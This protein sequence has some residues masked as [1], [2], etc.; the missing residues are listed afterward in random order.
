[1]G[2]LGDIYR[3]VSSVGPGR[4]AL[5]LTVEKAVSLVVGF[6]VSILIARHLGPE[7]FGVFSYV[8]AWIAVVAPLATLG[9]AGP[10]V[11]S[12][13]QD[14]LNTERVITT[15]MTLRLVAAV[16]V[17]LVVVGLIGS[18]LLVAGNG[19]GIGN[20]KDV[21]IVLSLQYLAQSLDVFEY[22]NQANGRIIQTVRAR[23]AAFMVVSALRVAAVYLGA[24]VVTFAWLVVLQLLLGFALIYFGTKPLMLRGSW[25]FDSALARKLLGMGSFIVLAGLLNMAQAR[26]EMIILEHFV[27]MKAV[28]IYAAALRF[29]ELFD[30][31][32]MIAVTIYL[33]HLLASANND[34]L[35]DGKLVR[36]YRMAILLYLVCI[37]L[38]VAMAGIAWWTMGDNY[39]GI[40]WLVLAMAV[41]P[42]LAFMG[43]TRG[44]SMLAESRLR[45]SALCAA[46]GLITAV[47]SA[48][49]LIPIFGVY[50]AAASGLMSYGV[51]NILIDAVLNK[52]YFQAFISAVTL[53]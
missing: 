4:D 17:A 37:P 2:I 52:R 30:T 25:L 7:Q 11:K 44:M 53:K 50:G 40:H 5:Y 18:G 26:S 20:V 29:I 33:P 21:A 47:T 22:Y 16:F 34:Q 28:G 31:G 6:A 51:S 41:R 38:I 49:L 23:L 3:R 46:V 48:Y 45:Y 13:V 9:L 10:V 19:Q 15:T 27:G 43:L 36:I 39:S 42:L 32:G 8:T 12:F 1:M 24:D 14:R 35:E